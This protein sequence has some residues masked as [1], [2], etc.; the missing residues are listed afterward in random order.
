M[1]H[2]LSQV[3]IKN[4]RSIREHT[5]DLSSFTPLVG[6]NNAGKSNILTAIEWLLRRS[7]LDESYFNDPSQPV[8]VIGK[9]EGI[10]TDLLDLLAANHR[11][12]LTPMLAGEVLT[13]KRIQSGPGG[14][15]NVKLLVQ[16]ANANGTEDEWKANPG[17]ID[18]AIAALFPEPIRIAAMQDAGEDV[19]K[20]MKTTTI[21][22]LL[23]E[24]IAPVQTNHEET[25]TAALAEVRS[26]LDSDGEH[27][28]QELIDF[29]TE[30]SD[31]IE[32]FFP[33]IRLKVHI[34]T[35][36]LKEVFSKGT[37]K[38]FEG[39]MANGKDIS[40]YGHGT[41]RSIQMAL[42][43][44]LADKKRGVDANASTTLLLIDEPELYLHPQAIEILRDAL[45]RL[46][47]EG[48]QVI[49]ST[50]S[51]SMVTSD[52]FLN[53]IL[54]RKGEIDG[55][56]CKKTLKKIVPDVVRDA[57]SQLELIFSLSHSSE[58]LFSE[59]VLLAE[60]KTER[61][62]LPKLFAK[63]NRKTLG[64]EKTAL[65]ILDGS[66][67]I[68][69]ASQVLLAMDLPAKI[70]CDMDFV[71]R[72]GETQGIVNPGDVDLVAI[73]SHLANIA[74]ANGI[75]L[76]GD[77]WPTK[78]ASLTAAEAFRLLA[79]EPA[80]QANL[81]NLHETAKRKRVWF[82]R[83]GDIEAH[84]NLIAKTE[85]AWAVLCKRLDSE[86]V[87]SVLPDDHGEITKFVTWILTDETNEADQVS[88]SLEP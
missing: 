28:A 44:H 2:I 11:T 86:E 66:G 65:V 3:T 19:S 76:D 43:R 10:D 26:L 30:V 24:I 75:V 84:L 45:K 41:Q 23:A 81:E 85:A 60:G 50:H 79:A 49:F 31:K 8:E 78:S 63:I 62:L 51:P 20:S 25:I 29:D 16:D 87:I 54:V 67:N 15:T 59:R 88:E 1:A 64:M 14:L 68:M 74:S 47:S 46:S 48:Y 7:A 61:R 57:S 52:D 82:W 34:P 71:L 22:K 69:K 9:I 77:G 32:A 83:K 13:I 70:I 42:I 12:A 33:G 53:T 18:N 40:S 56:Y 72:N 58:V 5:F 55:T 80:V 4:F 6:Y 73:K 35:P 21:G 17:G 27:R 38:V 36:E 39:G 37:I